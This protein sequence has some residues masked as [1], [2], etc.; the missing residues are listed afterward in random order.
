[1]L[2]F[3]RIFQENIWNRFFTKVLLEVFSIWLQVTQ[4]SPSILQYVLD[5]KI[6]LKSLI[7]VQSKEL[8]SILVEHINL[9]YGTLMTWQ[10]NL[11]DV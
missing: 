4:I 9:Y 3:L 10:L 8:S 5:F 7:L 2:N 1:M 6:T 11:L